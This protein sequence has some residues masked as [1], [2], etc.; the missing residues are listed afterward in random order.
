[1]RS[2]KFVGTVKKQGKQKQQPQQGN[3]YAQNQGGSKVT[4]HSVG[5]WD[6]KY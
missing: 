1:M 3:V 4:W 6:Q 2:E 5:E